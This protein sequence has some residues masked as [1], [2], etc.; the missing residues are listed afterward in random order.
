[1]KILEEV[2]R[3]NLMRLQV[4]TLDDLWYLSQI[5]TIGDIIK[6]KSTRKIKIGEKE[7][8]VKKSV[9]VPIKAEKGR[10]SRY[11]LTTLRNS[12]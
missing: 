7:S 5:I 6:G 12:K 1:M 9:I 3:Q 2:I 4:E 10:F 8:A 11:K